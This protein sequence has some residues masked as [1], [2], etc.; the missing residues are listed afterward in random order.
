MNIYSLWGALEH[1]D[2]GPSRDYDGPISFF[3]NESWLFIVNQ[4]IVPF[5][6]FFSC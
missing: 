1:P 5:C 6:N 4:I 3:I 2:L